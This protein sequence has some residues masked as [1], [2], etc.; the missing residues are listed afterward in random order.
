M[1]QQ[2]TTL[3]G[4]KATATAHREEGLSLLLV[5]L[6]TDEASG[7]PIHSPMAVSIVI[8]RS[9]SMD[10]EKLALTRSAVAQFIRSLGPDD[11]IAVVAYDEHVD[12]ICPLQAPSETLA[13]KVEAIE[14]RGSTDLYGGW[15]MGAK[16]VGK[17][18]RVILLSDGQANR[19]RFTD[20]QSLSHHSGISY[21]KFGVTTTTIGVGRDYDEGLMAGM[22]RAGG[23]AHYF[24]HA[25]ESITDAFS[26]ERYSAEAMVLQS[27]SVRC[28]KATEQFGHF[29]GGEIKKRIFKITDLKGL[30]ATVRFT[31]RIDGRLLTET[32]NMPSEFGYSEEVRLEYLLQLAGEAESAM[33]D[34]RDPKS[35]S[36]MK[37]RLRKVVLS[38]LAHPS[39]DTP[40]V[41]ATIERLKASIERLAQLE[42]N[43]VEEDAMVHRKRSLQVSYNLREPANAFSS[44][45]EDQDY[46]AQSA[47]IAS[48]TPMLREVVEISPEALALAP[49]EDW[50]RWEALPI[51]VDHNFVTVALEDPRRGFIRYDI[52]KAVK[53]TVKAIF[54]GISAAEIIGLLSE[55]GKL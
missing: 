20:A 2:T 55:A 14:A 22:A 13:R 53:R 3:S 6:A 34:V 10:G 19:G 4:L 9:G 24:A 37:E 25:A 29:W 27:V 5:E 38:L 1:N 44:F 18:G 42:M 47:R 40:S 41:A 23:G 7:G 8:D 28:G 51:G 43:Y 12:V 48:S 33:L 31:K 15:V 26:Q 54:A 17:G 30:Q 32:L 39:S 52:E 16:L 21:E 49:L 11:R 50:I 36:A 45:V 46:V 35:A